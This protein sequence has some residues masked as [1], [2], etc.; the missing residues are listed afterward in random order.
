MKKGFSFYS[1]NLLKKPGFFFFF[2]SGYGSG[3]GSSA[4]SGTSEGEG[5]PRKHLMK[6]GIRAPNRMVVMQTM[7]RVPLLTISVSVLEP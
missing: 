4:S 3:S 6:A 2:S 5:L 1:L 7:M